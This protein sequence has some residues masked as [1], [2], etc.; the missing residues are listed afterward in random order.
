MCLVE[1]IREVKLHKLYETALWT[2]HTELLSR[3]LTGWKQ[4]KWRKNEHNRRVCN[5]VEEMMVNNWRMEWTWLKGKWWMCTTTK[6]ATKRRKTLLFNIIHKGW[7]LL[8]ANLEYLK[9]LALII[10][11]RGVPALQIVLWTSSTSNQH[12]ETCFHHRGS[13]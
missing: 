11:L 1:Q 2:F 8:G 4:Q 9:D 13:I 6:E 7:V 12:R 5:V 10:M 3:K